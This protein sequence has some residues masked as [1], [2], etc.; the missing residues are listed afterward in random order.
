MAHARAVG[1]IAACAED[2][3]DETVTLL[4]GFIPIG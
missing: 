1:I 4:L 2:L 3:L